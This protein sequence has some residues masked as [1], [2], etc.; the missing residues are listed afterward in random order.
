MSTLLHPATAS[1]LALA[2]PLPRSAPR[3]RPACRAIEALLEP[4]DTPRPRYESIRTSP[5]AIAPGPRGRS[6]SSIVRST[7]DEEIDV[8][9]T[10]STHSTLGPEAVAAA[11][12]AAEAAGGAAA[13]APEVDWVVASYNVLDMLRWARAR[14]APLHLASVMAVAVAAAVSLALAPALLSPAS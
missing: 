14:V 11:A 3:P 2:P 10:L 1:A 4:A 8:A 6:V 9:A 5:L 13:R 12:A 7:G